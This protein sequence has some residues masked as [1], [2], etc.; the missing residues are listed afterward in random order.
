MY[1][2]PKIIPLFVFA[3]FSTSLIYSQEIQ[4][5]S[6]IWYF[7]DMAG[8]DFNTT[9]P[10][11]LTDGQLNTQE[12]VATVSN[13]LGELLFYTD[14][15]TVWDRNHQP[16]PN[17]N[18]ILSGH[19]SSTQSA[20][21][22]P[23]PGNSNQYYIFTTD[24][25]GGANGLSYT[26]IDISLPGNGSVGLPLGDAINSQT[27][28]QLVTPVTEK[29]TG[30]LK[31][32]FNG[33]WIVTHGW[34]NSLFY[35]YDITCAG[36]NHTPVISD[37]GNIHA[38]GIN[39]INTVGYMKSSLDGQRLAL[40]NRNNNSVDVYDFDNSTGIV[41]NEFEIIPNDNLLYGIEFS[42]SG[43]HLFIGGSDNISRYSF[44]TSSLISVI[45]NSNA[46]FNGGNAVRALQ[47]GPDENIYVSI[48]NW[49]FISVIYNSED[50]DPELTT[51][52]IYLDPDN[53]GR[54]CRFGL[55][56]IFYSDISPLDSLTITTCPSIP[57][58][59]NGEIYQ[60]GSINEVHLT[61]NAGC[62]STFVLTIEAFD[63]SEQT[64]YFEAC[65]ES[66]Y[67][68]DGV[69]IP[70]GTQE[71]F[72]Y[73]DSN[74]CD[75]VITIIVNVTEIIEDSIIEVLCE[76]E[77]YL[78]NNVEYPVGTDTIIQFIDQNG[79]ENAVSLLLSPSP[80]LDFDLAVE[81]ACWNMNNGSISVQNIQGGV[82]PFEFSIGNQA[83]FSDTIINNLGP[84]V[85]HF[86]IID[87]NECSYFQDVE[88][89]T[90]QEFSIDY[91]EMVIPCE[92]DSILIEVD[93]Y[94]THEDEVSWK[95]FDGSENNSIYVS[96]PGSYQ[97]EISNEC[98]ALTEEI[99]VEL[100]ERVNENFVY[101][102]NT[103]SPNFDGVNDVFQIYPARDI[104]LIDF[105]IQ[106]FN[107]WGA[108]LFTSKDINFAWDGIFKEK[109]L[110][111]GVYAW[112]LKVELISCKRAVSIFEK[113]DVTIVR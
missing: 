14:G 100:E 46:P 13:N 39:N 79:C 96:Q 50:N 102:P 66:F 20:L 52:G 29:I 40:V 113:G 108:Q 60:P 58:E 112:W 109:E 30:I 59:Y 95:W 51:N 98:Q 97:L 45:I 32:D 49:D 85:Y 24:E 4:N 68:F 90:I 28:I 78:Y 37:V 69:Q 38:G 9:P 111:P 25:L 5:S 2:N 105:E 84:N 6:N 88:I 80:S 1:I 43:D 23:H 76:G 73:T 44:N 16:M 72:T 86:Q 36:I 12:G 93:L 17:A 107:R 53:V 27:N 104:E 75:S 21:I 62:D 35:A 81:N 19:F 33:Y 22:V 83:Y 15:L 99:N 34:N 56:N 92:K 65:E 94:N 7:G 26:V 89:M 71:V 8:L 57:V 11:A 55:P 106:I 10:T 48:R 63:V 67:E 61:T 77:T 82:P 3:L 42:S 64:L 18:G 54:E 41:S 110:N 87:D 31:P 101:I 47:L 103:F 70:A 91:P 74:G